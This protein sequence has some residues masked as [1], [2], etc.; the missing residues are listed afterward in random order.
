MDVVALLIIVSQT[1]HVTQGVWQN[2]PILGIVKRPPIQQ[3]I[4]ITTPQPTIEIALTCAYCQ[5][6]EH[7]FKIVPLWMIN[8][9]N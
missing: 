3:N 1:Q 6:V 8:S 4:S 7:E 5:Q 2:I 9:N